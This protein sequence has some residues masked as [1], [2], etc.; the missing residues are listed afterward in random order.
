[1]ASS[2]GNTQHLGVLTLVIELDLLINHRCFTNKSKPHNKRQR[3][4]AKKQAR[5]ARKQQQAKNAAQKN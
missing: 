4:N 2:A 5:K 1:M 3:K